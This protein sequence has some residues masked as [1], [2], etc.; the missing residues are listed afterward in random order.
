ML[1]V[2]NKLIEIFENIISPPFC[3]YCKEFTD[4][5]TIL[6]IIC[7]KLIKPVLS[8]K[9]KINKDYD[10]TV[11]AVTAYKEPFKSLI[12]AKSFSDYTSSV[13][14]AKLIWEHSI[15][16]NL[17]YD[18]FIPVPLH[19]VR[20]TN[21][22]YNQ[23]EV[24]AKELSRFSSKPVL[25]CLKRNKN[26][27]FQSLLPVD[28]RSKNVSD[29]FELNIK[30]KSFYEGKTLVL[31][32]DLLTTGSTLQACAKKLVTLKP[33]AIIAIVACRVVKI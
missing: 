24:M 9:I 11:H 27:V 18:Y 17:S 14:L 29:A 20:Y 7:Q 1:K 4:K 2:F 12:L 31:V 6:C 16:K 23:A 33:K 3:V 21:R 8:H 22:G 10:I 26:T 15:I 25:N 32:D 19:W 28:L 13:Q 5:R 30:D